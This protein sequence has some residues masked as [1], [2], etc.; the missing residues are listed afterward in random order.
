M[1]GYR[2]W[3]IVTGVCVVRTAMSIWMTGLSVEADLHLTGAIAA[4]ALARTFRLD[5]KF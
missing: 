3:L 5:S 4:L 2:F 1:N